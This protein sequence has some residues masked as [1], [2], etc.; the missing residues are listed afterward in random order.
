M[1]NLIDM[2]SSPVMISV[3]LLLLL[4]VL[5]LNVVFSI[6][7]SA[8]VGG[9]VAGMSVADIMNSFSA[10]LSNGAGIAFNYAMLGAFSIAISRSGLT[11]L[12]AQKLF[13]WINGEVT[14]KK[15]FVF[16]YTL[17]AILTVA[18]IMSQN[19][20]PVH[21]AFIPILIPPL[22]CVF[23]RIRLDRRAVACILTFGLITPYMVFP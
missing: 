3:A 19:I 1:N 7:I 12:L 16:K 6:I 15:L 8:L 20:I 13:S 11:E 4:S 18:S 9:L 10:G 22:L 2:L 5:R 14:P 23:E 21:I 17:L